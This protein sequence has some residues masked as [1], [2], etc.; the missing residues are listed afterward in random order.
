MNRDKRGYWYKSYREGDKVHR[1][2]LGKGER[3]EAMGLIEALERE[4]HEEGAW[5]AKEEMAELAELDSELKTVAEA[6]ELLV[7]AAMLAA[8]YHRHNRGEWR[9]QRVRNNS[10]G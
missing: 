1:Q 8:G 7:H 2:Y 10:N 9:K 6:I 5:M 4:K 3:A